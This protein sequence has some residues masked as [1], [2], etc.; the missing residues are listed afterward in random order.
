MPLECVRQQERYW[1]SPLGLS[2]VCEMLG[3]NEV[4]GSHTRRDLSLSIVGHYNEIVIIAAASLD[5]QPVLIFTPFML[6]NLI[7]E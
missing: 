7:N 2:R 3:T 4:T 1:G 5:S 6:F